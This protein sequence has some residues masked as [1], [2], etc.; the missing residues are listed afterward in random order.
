M[1]MGCKDVALWMRFDFKF[2]KIKPIFWKS[3]FDYMWINVL[4]TVIISS[5]CKLY[6][7]LWCLVSVVEMKN[8]IIAIVFSSVLQFGGM[9]LL[10][11]SVPR[12]YIFIYIM[13]ISAYM[14]VSRFSYRGLCIAYNN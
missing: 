2:S 14:I 11:Y 1:T 5:I 7:S 3:V 6:T 9:H 13:L 12:S 8:I 10:G 4:C